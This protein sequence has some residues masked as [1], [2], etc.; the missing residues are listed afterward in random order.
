M[1]SLLK[2]SKSWG[3]YSALL[4]GIISFVLYFFAPNVGISMDDPLNAVLVALVACFFAFLVMYA[5][6]Y[7]LPNNSKK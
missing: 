2:K 6:E 1:P 3:F 5:A 4:I 7:F